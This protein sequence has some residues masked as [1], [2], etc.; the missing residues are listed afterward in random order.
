[1]QHPHSFANV[2]CEA[3]ETITEFHTSMNSV[4]IAQLVGRTVAYS[5]AAFNEVTTLASANATY[6][7]KWI[8]DKLRELLPNAVHDTCCAHII[9]MVGEEFRASL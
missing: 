2:H 4:T 6:M 5:I 8:T 3:I 7:N 9:T 1:M